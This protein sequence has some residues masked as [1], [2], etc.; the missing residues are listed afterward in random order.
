MSS[1][2]EVSCLRYRAHTE[3]SPES[4]H[5]KESKGLLEVL[6]LPSTV[7]NSD[8]RRVRI[9]QTKGRGLLSQYVFKYEYRPA[10]LTG[11]GRWSRV[12]APLAECVPLAKLIPLVGSKSTSF[13]P[14]SSACRSADRPL[15]VLGAHVSRG[16]VRACNDSK[17]LLAP[18]DNTAGQR[19]VYHRIVEQCHEHE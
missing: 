7:S 4:L 3:V 17:V 13:S 12:E 14:K 11:R 5:P 10:L 9:H 18:I 19:E 2:A 1:V 6:H 16:G 15:F 8:L